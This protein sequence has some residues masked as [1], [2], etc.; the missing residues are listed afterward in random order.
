MPA[1]E[2]SSCLL[3]QCIELQWSFWFGLFYTPA[4]LVVISALAGYGMAPGVF[5]L[6]TCAL[7]G[8][9][10]FMTSCS[11]NTV[12]QVSVHTLDLWYYNNNESS[13]SFVQTLRWTV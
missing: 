6:S 12:N 3:N 8:L 2:D 11:A 13:P 9:G 5:E 7:M 4:G 1:W 10:T